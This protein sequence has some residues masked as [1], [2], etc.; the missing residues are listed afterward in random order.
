[1]MA[2]KNSNARPSDKRFNPFCGPTS[3]DLAL[4]S[5]RMETEIHDL[6]MALLPL[7]DGVENFCRGLDCATQEAIAQ[8]VEGLSLLGDL[9][10]NLKA[11]IGLQRIGGVGEVV[12]REHYEI[13]DT[14][15]GDDIPRGTVLKVIQSGWVFRGHTIRPAKVAV[16][17]DS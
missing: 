15:R 7:L 1:M 11:Q 2:E 3:L 10:D 17:S 14:L 8:K 5:Q 9:A 13:V 6:A 4:E 16:S 12:D